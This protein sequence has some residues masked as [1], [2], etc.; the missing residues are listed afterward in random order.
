MSEPIVVVSM[1]DD[2]YLPFAAVV[3]QSIAANAA[4]GRAIDYHVFHAGTDRAAADTLAAFH[5]GEVRI[6]VHRIDNPLERFGFVGYLSA[7]TLMRL[8]LP[9]L[10]PEHQRIIYLDVDLMVLGDIAEL[11]ATDLHGNAMAAVTA[12]VSVLAARRNDP[13]RLPG[14]GYTAR[15][16]LE[17]VIGL[18]ADAYAGYVNTGVLIMDMEALRAQDFSHRAIAYLEH[19]NSRL[20]FRDQ[21]AINIVLKDQIALLDPAWNVNNL[22]IGVPTLDGAEQRD[23]DIVRRQLAGPKCFHYAGTQKPWRQSRMLPLAGLWWHFAAQTPLYGRIK[24]IHRAALLK[25]QR[26]PNPLRPLYAAAAGL[27]HA[28]RGSSRPL[29]HRLIE[30]WSV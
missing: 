9:E 30:N 26:R 14:E 25:R 27:R 22:I 24:D 11:A 12:I 15:Q 21:D 19:N 5:P 8:L 16:H 23:I 4:P 6:V 10:M 20:P 18:A 2:A 7:S 28:V 13:Y 29:R 1:V 3:A 17:Q